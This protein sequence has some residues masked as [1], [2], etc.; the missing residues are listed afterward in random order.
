MM[1]NVSVTIEFPDEEEAK[2][3]LAWMSDGGG[4]QEFDVDG[5]YDFEY[6]IDKFFCRVTEW[7]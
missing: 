2:R 4:E 7:A 6:D 5:N 3:F 1:N